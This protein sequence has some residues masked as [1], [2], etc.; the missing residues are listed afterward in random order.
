MSTV[1][2]VPLVIVMMMLLVGR[3][4][5][6]HH[7]CQSSENKSKIHEK[8]PYQVNMQKCYIITLATQGFITSVGSPCVQHNNDMLQRNNSKGI[9]DAIS[10]L[11]VRLPN[12]NSRRRPCPNAPITIIWMPC[13]A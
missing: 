4:V 12:S 2:T 9:F 10:I 3:R 6:G 7:R 11:A 13:S 8:P 1:L 5:N